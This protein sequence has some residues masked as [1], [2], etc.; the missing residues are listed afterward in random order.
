ME[1]ALEML[2]PAQR[3]KIVSADPKVVDPALVY[4]TPQE[5]AQA[6]MTNQKQDRARLYEVS[7]TN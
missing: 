2:N 5:Y 3:R 7:A 1:T 4:S 6:I